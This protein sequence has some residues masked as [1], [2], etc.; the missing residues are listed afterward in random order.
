MLNPRILNAAANTAT[1]SPLKA[2]Q[3]DPKT[4]EANH[5]AQESPVSTFSR[6]SHKLRQMQEQLDAERHQA[7]DSLFTDSPFLGGS[8]TRPKAQPRYFA[9]DADNQSDSAL[10]PPPLPLHPLAP[11]PLSTGTSLK[12]ESK[13]PKKWR[14]RLNAPTDS[15]RA[16]SNQ[17]IND[18]MSQAISPKTGSTLQAA[19]RAEAQKNAAAQVLKHAGASASPEIQALKP[20]GDALNTSSSLITKPT[21]PQKPHPVSPP[22]EIIPN[23]PVAPT[24]TEET[25]T[26]TQ[27]LANWAR[28]NDVANSS[29]LPCVTTSTSTAIPPQPTA[30]AIPPNPLSHGSQ[31]S[32]SAGVNPTSKKQKGS[33]TPQT[34]G[35]MGLANATQ[36]LQTQSV[37]LAAV[38]EGGQSQVS[39]IKKASA[40]RTHAME[41]TLEGGAMADLSGYK[42]LSKPP[43]MMDDPVEAREMPRRSFASMPEPLSPLSGSMTPNLALNPDAY[44]E[45]HPEVDTDFTGNVQTLIRLVSDLPDGVTKQ[46]GA[47]IIR[48]TMEAMGISMEEVLGEAQSAQSEMLEAVR[49]NIKKI[50]EYKTVIRKLENDIKHYQGKANELSE[51]IDLFILSNTSQVKVTPL[52][53]HY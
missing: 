7:L 9:V 49:A 36:T 32:P 18:P 5:T 3:P 40:I 13:P 31:A 19:Q 52:D 39:S 22:P 8:A 25:T 43:V 24:A 30:V 6:L 28:G 47:Q 34:P 33:K 21:A 48:L 51:I 1:P 12:A 44:S 2:L 38:A 15:V 50:E 17:A 14:F 29:P 45:M 46:T 23:T 4:L 20:L 35:R 53:A 16:A 11:P 37:P 26:W 27:R 10:T 41:S 42:D